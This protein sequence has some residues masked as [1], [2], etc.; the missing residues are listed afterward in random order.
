MKSYKELAKVYDL[1][2]QETPYSTWVE[3]IESI[4]KKYNL[5][6]NLI[7]ELGCGTG[8]IT[9][10]MQDKGYDM[11]GVDISEDMLAEAKEKA[12]QKKQDILFLN[13]DMCEFELFGTVDSCICICDSLNYILEIE[14]IL[15]TFKLVNNYLNPKGLFIFDLN[16]E[17]KFKNILS[18]NSFSATENNAAYIW[19][20]YYYEDEM[21]NE[22]Y[23]NI[24]IK[25]NNGQYSRHEEYHYQKAYKK[26]TI[27]ELLKKAGLEILGIY[28]SFS[29]NKPKHDSE[30][31]IFIAQEN[32]K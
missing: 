2:M 27:I 12:Q 14:D 16:T 15:K 24:F 3:Y 29:F 31:I 18:D 13:Q 30:R 22:Y 28:D 26:E 17:Y 21:I 20:N 25:D 1:F 19:E 6:P 10:L 5:S 11:I 7:L 32:S 23:T 9:S 8:N 4:F